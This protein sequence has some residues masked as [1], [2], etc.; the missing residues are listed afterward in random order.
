MDIAKQILRLLYKYRCEFGKT[1][2]D[3]SIT[4]GKFLSGTEIPNSMFLD[5]TSEYEVTE[6]VK[7]FKLGK[8]AGYDNISMNMI[9]QSIEFISKPLTHIINLSIVDGIVPDQMKIAR[10]IPVFKCDDYSK[11]NNYRPIS[12]LPAFSKLLEGIMYDR[13]LKFIE[14]YN[15]LSEQQYGFRKGRS[16]V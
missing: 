2:P 13:L 4:P 5:P 8:A 7:N 11:F 9:K 6:A 14:K 16:T 3:T 10:V 1:I 12:V 15:I